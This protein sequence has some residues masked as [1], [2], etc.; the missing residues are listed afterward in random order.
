MFRPRQV[1]IRW[2]LGNIQMVM[3]YIQTTT[4][5]VQNFVELKLAQ[6][7]LNTKY[8]SDFKMKIGHTHIKFFFKLNWNNAG[9]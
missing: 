8:S 5:L 3:E 2:F 9:I 1:I 4:M 7:Q 6:I